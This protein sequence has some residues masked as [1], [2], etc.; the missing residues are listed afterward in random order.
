MRR[1]SKMRC[2]IG[3]YEIGMRSMPTLTDLRIL[4]ADLLAERAHFADVYSRRRCELTRVQLL[5]CDAA[6]DDTYAAIA[7]LGACS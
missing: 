1:Y 7:E 3:R 2:P 6:L 4:L 5:E